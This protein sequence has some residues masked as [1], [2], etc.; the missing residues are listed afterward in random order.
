M[1]T[2]ITTAPTF[3]VVC[4][5]GG[6]YTLEHAACLRR[7]FQ[8]F[9]TDKQFQ[10]WC[11]TDT[12]TEPW[13]IRLETDWPGWWAVQ[14]AWRFTGPTILTGLDTL[15]CRH[16][17]PFTALAKACGLNQVWGTHDFTKP[18]WANAV[19]IWNGDHRDAAVGLDPDTKDYRGE[20]DFTAAKCKGLGLD[21]LYMDDVIDG[22]ISY[23]QHVH[24]PGGSVSEASA[25]VVCWYARPR[26]WEDRCRATWAGKRYRQFLSGSHIFKILAPGS[27]YA[28][29][30]Q[31]KIAWKVLEEDCF[32]NNE[33]A[34]A[35]CWLTYRAIDGDI[36]YDDWKKHIQGQSS[37][38]EASSPIECRWKSSQITAE[39]YLHLLNGQKEETA[40]AI[41]D[42]DRLTQCQGADLWP[43]SVLNWLRAK[44]IYVY[45]RFLDDL[46]Y[47][48]EAN[49][50]INQW[51][52]LA[53][54]YDFCKWNLRVDEM[55]NDIRALNILTTILIPARGVPWLEPQKMVGTKELFHR[56]LLKL[57]E[58][59]PNALFK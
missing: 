58:D 1:L 18:K 33:K 46:P 19:M 2:P 35:K 26:P 36:T 31:F 59:N 57:G 11:L 56:C 16:L 4:R 7:Q 41:I 3:V 53:H 52:R 14:E 28:R 44:V 45:G 30:M 37:I 43:P 13:H 12:P 40:Q 55:L 15:F 25:N 32:S 29:A 50:T 9:N 54:S 42:L 20:M 10:F 51:R 47:Q 24:I 17:T 5:S 38:Q 48:E 8:A 49:A 21:L 27:N 23:K 39:V 22:I 34:N 6:D